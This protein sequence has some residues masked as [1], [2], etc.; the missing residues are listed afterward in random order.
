MSDTRRKEYFFDMH[1]Y[2]RKVDKSLLKKLFFEHYALVVEYFEDQTKKIPK[3]RKIYQAFKGE[4]SLLKADHDD[5]DE[6]FEI[7]KWQ[8]KDIPGNFVNKKKIPLSYI[9]DFIA[10]INS[11]QKVYNAIYCNCQTFVSE[12]LIFLGVPP[13]L[14]KPYQVTDCIASLLESSTQIS[15]YLA[16][17]F[18]EIPKK[19]I[20]KV[21]GLSE[22]AKT[23]LV[24]VFGKEATQK[25]LE[26]F[27]AEVKTLALGKT[28]LAWETFLK[29]AEVLSIILLKY[30]LTEFRKYK[31]D[32]AKFYAYLFSKAVA[33]FGKGITVFIS[34]NAKVA[35]V[36]SIIVAWIISE[37]VPQLIQG[38]ARYLLRNSDSAWHLTNSSSLSEM[39]MSLYHWS[40][41]N[42]IRITESFNAL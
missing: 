31:E 24:E 26:E 22:V 41:P 8:V 29:L 6:E 15:T 16:F 33:L 40:S 3:Y 4:G 7:H 5:L 28:F 9:K 10:A 27:T 12:I 19:I 17:L 32:D 14:H 35:E 13:S 30:Y 1:V 11:Q 20:S 36:M 34:G 25:I 39:L 2:S 42:S 38:I 23:F 37:I 21:V 18:Q